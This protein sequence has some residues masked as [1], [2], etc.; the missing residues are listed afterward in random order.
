MEPLERRFV[1]AQP[2]DLRLTLAIH[3]R[4]PGD[5]TMRFS[6]DGSTWRTTRTPEGPATLRLVRGRRRDPGAGVGAGR[7]LGDRAGTRAG[8]RRRRPRRL[9]GPGGRRPVPAARYPVSTL[10]RYPGGTN[11]PR[12]GG[13]GPG[14]HRAEGDRRRG[15]QR[16]RGPGPAP[17][18]AGAG[19]VGGR[20][21]ARR[22]CAW[23]RR[24]SCWPAFPGTPT[25]RSGSSV[26]GPTRSASPRPGRPA[27]RSAPTMPLPDA[28][29]R[30]RA[31]PL[32]GP[33]DGRG[34]R[35]AGA[36]R[37]GRGERRRLPPRPGGLLGARARGARHRRADAGAPR[38]VRRASRARDPAHRGRRDPCPAPRSP[39]GAALD[40][41]DLR[42]QRGGPADA[43]PA[44]RPW[45][46]GRSA[47]GTAPAA[48]HD[49]A[50]RR[51]HSPGRA[52]APAAAPS[53]LVGL[54]AAASA[55]RWLRWIAGAGVD[56]AAAWPP[57]VRPRSA[58]SSFP[59][60]RIRA[61]RSRRSFGR[62][63]AP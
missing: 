36:R 32:V 33:V 38:A 3:R 16:V 55:R 41:R 5:P 2:V 57:R 23:C 13:A 42:V 10:P 62:S 4:G 1:P 9:R 11:R 43:R 31:L 22:R 51:T 60:A 59:V 34:G 25:T 45:H 28:Y 30:L 26:D 20:R 19:A 39:D 54:S 56:P 63:R 12:P 50:M 48:E 44:V 61:A 18:R 29:A 24:R 58:S 46:M 6:R 49:G 27:S 8:R 37:P 52:S 47:V 40:R 53:S 21:D 35:P 15:A 7:R 14:D 17:R